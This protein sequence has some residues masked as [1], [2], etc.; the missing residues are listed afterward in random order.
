MTIS[1]DNIKQIL[2]SSAESRN[3]D[4]KRGFEWSTTSKET[5]EIVKDIL[6]FS[7][8]QDGGTLIIGIDDQTREFSGEP[9]CWW[10]T[11]DPTKIMNT[12]NRYCAPRINLTVT[13]KENF[14]HNG[15]QGTIVVLQISEFESVPILSIKPGNTSDNEHVFR[16]PALFIRTN[17]ASSEEI[18]NPDDFRDLINR[19]VLKNGEQ[20]LQAFNAIVKGRTTPQPTIP[21]SQ[22]EDEIRESREE[23]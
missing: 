14:E 15:N 23:F 7:N 13:I 12:V 2:S 16:S 19:A 5:L 6:A 1:D 21:F 18:S 3:Y 22:Y 10:N 4:F 9:D 17:S 8:T 11:F 20:I